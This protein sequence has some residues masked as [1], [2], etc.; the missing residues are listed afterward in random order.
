MILINGNKNIEI[1][2]D[3]YEFPYDQQAQAYDNNWLNIKVIWEDEVMR[4]EGIDPCMTTQEFKQMILDLQDVVQSKTEAYTSSFTEP[5][6]SI[7]VRPYEHGFAFYL[8]FLKKNLNDPFVFVKQ[9]EKDELELLIQDFKK[10][11]ELFPIR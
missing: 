2:I 5:N 1:Q 4:Q 8:S 3:S 9:M 6:L 11:M 10:Q 7:K